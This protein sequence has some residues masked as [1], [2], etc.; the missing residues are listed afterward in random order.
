[1]ILFVV[2]LEDSGNLDQFQ[3]GKLL[4]VFFQ[5][6]SSLCIPLGKIFVSDC[7]TSLLSK[8]TGY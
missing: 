8:L 7:I 4:L 2:L 5:S 6:L 3:W 1:M